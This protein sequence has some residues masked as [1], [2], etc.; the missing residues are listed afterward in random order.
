M[1]GINKSKKK[2]KNT[3]IEN[4]RLIHFNTQYCGIS[5]YSDTTVV[6]TPDSLIKGTLHSKKNRF[7][8]EEY[9]LNYK[10]NNN[11]LGFR[12]GLSNFF[13]SDAALTYVIL[14]MEEEKKDSITLP[15]PKNIRVGLST[16]IKSRRS[17]RKYSNSS[18]SLQDLSNIFY[19]AQGISDEVDAYNIPSKK[20][21]LRN[22]PSAGGLYPIQLFT[23]IK[24]VK[25]IKDGVYKYYPY[26]HS[27]KPVKIKKEIFKVRSLAEFGIINAENSNLII[28]YVYNFLKNSRKYGDNGLNYAL[29]ET[30]ETA[31][32]I[33]LLSTA[34]GY[35]CC[36]IG[37]YEKHYIEDILNLDG[38]FNH[39]IHMTIV[40]LEEN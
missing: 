30:G 8:S 11:N 23:Y 36:D 28:F 37:G 3:L 13:S 25:D 29:I 21:K 31:Q 20:I 10:W 38:I 34:L 35:G 40:G 9:L 4:M 16:T 33:Q 7:L 1:L 12:I 18:M 6:K 15:N 27:L 24:N 39:V 5:P 17:V 19:Y 14:D 32:N 22:S 26:S 2:K